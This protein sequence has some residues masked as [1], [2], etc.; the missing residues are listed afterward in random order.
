MNKEALA[1][2]LF[3][4]H[5]H[6]HSMSHTRHRVLNRKILFFLSIIL[7]T[8]LL[9]LVVGAGLLAYGAYHQE[10]PYL[11]ASGGCFAG[12][13]LLQMI[14]GLESSKVVCPNCRSQI[15]QV[16][17][18]SKHKQ[19]KKLFGSYSLRLALQVI[20]TNHFRCQ[21]C[22]QSYQWRGRRK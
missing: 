11:Y 21:Y 16:K 12:L 18:C 8:R 4:T 17:Q 7:I 9:L 20:F 10:L 19:A 1:F 14:H 5:T 6:T 3:P 13:L 22:S 15:L 2:G